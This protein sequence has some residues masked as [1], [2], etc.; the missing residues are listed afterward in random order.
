MR[1]CYPEPRHAYPARMRSRPQASGGDRHAG[2]ERRS[3]KGLW[4]QSRAGC[5]VGGQAAAEPGTRPSVPKLWE[6]R[7]PFLTESLKD[8]RLLRPP[9]APGRE[10]I[11]HSFKLAL[12]C[13]QTPR[14]WEYRGAQV[15]KVPARSSPSFLVPTWAPRTWALPGLAGIK[16]GS[17][18]QRKEW[19]EWS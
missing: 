15:S 1:T 7:A 11:W 19:G 4:V 6:P 10:Y 5:G 17:R 3:R 9:Y 14:K 8:L 16:P 2:V 18:K 13:P 12:G